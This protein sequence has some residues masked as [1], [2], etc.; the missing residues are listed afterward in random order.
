M[1]HAVA[2]NDAPSIAELLVTAAA[3][4]VPAPGCEPWDHGWCLDSYRKS[5]DAALSSF[6]G[7]MTL[8]SQGIKAYEDA[9][10][11]LLQE[12]K[13]SARWDP[14]EFWELVAVTVVLSASEIA[15]EERPVYVQE[16]IDF[17]RNAGKALTVQLVANVT[18][19]YPALEF[20]SASIG[21]ANDDF[22]S[23]TNAASRGRVQ[24]DEQLWESWKAK[25]VEPRMTEN[26]LEPVAIACWTVGQNEL[27]F[28]ET[29]RQLRDIVDLALLLERDLESHKIYR[30]S[31]R[32]QGACARSRSS[33][34]AP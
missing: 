5:E 16:K 29:E 30:K 31:P 23:F 14:E 28:G 24:L 3:A 19:G 22:L 2:K 13:I 18:W 21:N 9:V 33:R 15:V 26:P 20:G 32:D 10:M 11:R 6:R 1:L 25:Y 8:N 34:E 12:S 17:L 27:A 7:P 4:V